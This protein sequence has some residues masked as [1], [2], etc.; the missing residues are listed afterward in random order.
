MEGS[1][2]GQDGDGGQGDDLPVREDR[3]QALADQVDGARKTLGTKV[4]TGALPKD[5]GRRRDGVL[6]L[7]EAKEVFAEG[8]SI[9]AREAAIEANK[10]SPDLIPA[11]VLA[12]QS[13]AD[14]ENKRYASR[15]LAKA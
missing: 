13:Y 9:R 8:N 12:A 6:A 3:F 10:L 7:Q 14:Q 4:K 15:L 11:A 1:A 5:V 2:A